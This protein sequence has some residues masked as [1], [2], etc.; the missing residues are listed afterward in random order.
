MLSRTVIAYSLA[1][2]VIVGVLIPIGASA[3]FSGGNW[4][5]EGTWNWPPYAGSEGGMPGT[6]C[7]YVWVNPYRHKPGYGRWVYRCH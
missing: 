4:P 1:T 5:Q 3:G 2:A 6:T 7:S